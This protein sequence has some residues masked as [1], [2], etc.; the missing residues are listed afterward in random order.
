[1]ISAGVLA[2]HMGAVG[3]DLSRMIHPYPTILESVGEA[4]DMAHE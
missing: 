1:M 3:Y 2:L 4:A